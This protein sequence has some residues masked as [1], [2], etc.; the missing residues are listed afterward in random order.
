MTAEPRRTNPL[1]RDQL[2]T[3]TTALFAVIAIVCAV[4]GTIMLLG[5]W[6]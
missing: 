5:D 6:A 2:L 1:I 4:A 3:V